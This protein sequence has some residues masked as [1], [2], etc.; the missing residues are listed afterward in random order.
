MAVGQLSEVVTGLPLSRASPL[1]QGDSLGQRVVVSPQIKCG[2]WLAWDGGGS[3]ARSGDWAAAIAGKPAPTGGSARGREFWCRHK[4][5]VGA[6][7]P[8]MAVG[9]LSE[10]VTG[11]PLSRASPLPQGI[12][13]GQRMLAP[14]QIK[15]GSWLA[16][17]R[18]GSAASNSDWTAAFASK[19]APTGDL[20]GAEN[21]GT[22]TN[23]M[24]ELACLRWRWI[25][26]QKQ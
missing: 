19:P 13:A 11:L 6:G 23:Q 9:Q 10:V 12:C 4:S 7:L 2:S 24:W 8:A 17:D 26:R 20:R 5:N 1:P 15:C 16:C 18:G 22:T 14:P 25:S 3:V 21:F